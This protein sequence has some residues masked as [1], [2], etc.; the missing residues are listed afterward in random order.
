MSKVLEKYGI[1]RPQRR[2][3]VNGSM[4]SQF[5]SIIALPSADSGLQHSIV[6]LHNIHIGANKIKRRTPVVI[7][8]LD[9]QKKVIRYA[10]G[11]GG[12]VKKL[13]KSTIALDYDGVNDLGVYFEQ[14]GRFIV[15]EATLVE[16]I[17]SLL[18]SADLN[19]RLNTRIALLSAALG[20]CSA[21]LAISTIW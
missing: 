14:E 20:I 21:I 16:C 3:E 12:T 7:K 19:V 9:N 5:R 10:M 13:T 15:R 11:N 6:R 18:W 8:N 2:V 1:E 17:E 4:Y